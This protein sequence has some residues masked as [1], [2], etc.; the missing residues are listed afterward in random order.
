M[1]PVDA[2]FF[3]LDGTLIDSKHDLAQAVRYIQKK[4]RHVLSTDEEVG[5]FIGDGVLKLVQ[6][7]LPDFHASRFEEAVLVFKDYYRAHC[8]DHTYV[9]PGVFEMLR[10]FRYKKLAVVTNKP[11]R[12]SGRLLE[13]L[14]LSRYFQLVI[15]G[16]SLPNKKPHPEPMLN[17]MK[18][19]TLRDRKKVLMV[20]DSSNDIQAGQAAKIRTCGILSNIGD[21]KKLLISRPDFVISDMRE[22]MRFLD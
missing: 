19:L 6:R 17:A 20:G 8:M 14:K 1:I 5:T 15:G 11:V 9:Y 7:A 16:D 10:Y 12:I 18:T 13:G 21:P 4:Y 2:L 22:L 3:D